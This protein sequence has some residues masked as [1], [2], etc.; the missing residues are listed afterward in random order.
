MGYRRLHSK[1]RQSSLQTRKLIETTLPRGRLFSFLTEGALFFL[2]TALDSLLACFQIQ[3]LEFLNCAI[4][5]ADFSEMQEKM[6]LI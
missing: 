3:L 6:A 5:L 2:P 4:E 1:S